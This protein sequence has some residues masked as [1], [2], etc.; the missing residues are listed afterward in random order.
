MNGVGAGLLGLDGGGGLIKATIL[1][2]SGNS[3]LGQ[4]CYTH[5]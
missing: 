5:V 4:F 1:I 2:F 3:F